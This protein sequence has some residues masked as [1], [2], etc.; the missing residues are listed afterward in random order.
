MSIKKSVPSRKVPVHGDTGEKR[1]QPVGHTLAVS[2]QNDNDISAGVFG[3]DHASSNETFASLRAN[4][5]HFSPESF[6][7]LF[8][9]AFEML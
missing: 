8:Q 9:F 6:D 3:S 1:R 4:E 5:L 7:V 2:V